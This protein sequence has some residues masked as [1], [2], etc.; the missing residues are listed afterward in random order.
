[1]AK[2]S[3][4]YFKSRCLCRDLANHA[5]RDQNGY[6]VAPQMYGQGASTFCLDL[7]AEVAFPATLCSLS[8]AAPAARLG[9]RRPD[10]QFPLHHRFFGPGRIFG[11]QP[12]PSPVQSA[13]TAALV[14]A[15]TKR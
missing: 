15:S 10:R 7:G 3:D 2:R 4:K 1:M 12:P 6:G 13:L 8:W 5:E 9:A 11:Q 14:S